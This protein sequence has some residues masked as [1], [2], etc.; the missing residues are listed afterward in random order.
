[1][2]QFYTQPTASAKSSAFCNSQI[3]CLPATG[4]QGAAGDNETEQAWVPPNT[5][6]F[7]P[8]FLPTPPP[9][10]FALNGIPFFPLCLA[11]SFLLKCRLVIS[12]SVKP[13]L[14]SQAALAFPHPPGPLPHAPATHR[15]SLYH[16]TDPWHQRYGGWELLD[17][18]GGQ[19][20][21]CLRAPS[22]GHGT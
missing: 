4:I 14:T 6:L 20:H 7:V 19:T 10:W 1:M 22:Q 16:S 15:A 11:R 8:C 17:V 18:R 3:P 9:M 12:S 13:T 2:F 21:L 5:I